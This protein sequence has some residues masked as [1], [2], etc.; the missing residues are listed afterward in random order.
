M[1]GPI[2]SLPRHAIKAFVESVPLGEMG[3]LE[4]LAEVQLKS[5]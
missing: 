2:A 5:D 1:K 3:E 4:E